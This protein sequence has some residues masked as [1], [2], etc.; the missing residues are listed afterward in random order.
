MLSL[1]ARLTQWSKYPDATSAEPPIHGLERFRTAL[2][3]DDVNLDTG[4]FEFA[5]RFGEHGRQIAQARGAADSDG[6]FRLRQRQARRQNECG[7][8]GDKVPDNSS[9]K[10][11]REHEFLPDFVYGR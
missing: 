1:A 10:N 4:L 11:A 3:L 7:K 9:R 2:E 8:R 6:H 5:Q